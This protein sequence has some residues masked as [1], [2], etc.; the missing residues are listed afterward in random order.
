MS[1]RRSNRIS[2]ILR[3]LLGEGDA[4]EYETEATTAHAVS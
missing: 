2:P 3:A 4:G 1:R